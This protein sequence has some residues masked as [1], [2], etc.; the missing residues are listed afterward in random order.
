M[1]K[2]GSIFRAARLLIA[3]A[4]SAVL[5]AGCA[6]RSL[7]RF[8][9]IAKVAAKD[10]YLEAVG[11]IRKEEGLYGSQAK[12]LYNMDLGILFHYA[13]EW[14][15]SIV[16]L[17][18][19]VKIHDA[20]FT[21][22]VTN[23][24]VSFVAN[25]NARP[26][27]GRPH[28]M[29]LVH[30]FLAFD[31]LAKGKPDEAR[32]EARQ[33]QILL[34]EI[35]RK[36]GPKDFRDDGMFRYFSALTYEAVGERDDAAISYYQSVKAY[37]EG[38]V[39]LPGAVARQA[40]LALASAGREDDIK[41]LDLSQAT[42]PTRDAPGGA[43][44]AAGEGEIIVVGHAGRAPTVDQTVFWGT[45]VRDG[46]L[47]IHWRNAK[48]EEFTEALP[49]PGLPPRELEKAEKGRRTRSGTTLHIKFAMPE[50]KTIPSRTRYFTVAGADLGAPVRTES[51]TD[52]DGL[53]REDLEDNR[54]AVLA[55]TVARVVLRTIASQ[56][57]KEAL[58]TGNPILNLL[59]NIGTDVLSDQLEQADSRCWFLLPRSIQVARIPVKPGTHSLTVAAQDGS[60]AVIKTRT[61]ES[62]TVRAGEKKYLFMPS[63][64]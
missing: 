14:D 24:A 25:D 8:E 38:A 52:L 3:G 29:I 19:A 35:R 30:Q 18:E 63:L 26:Y 55:R 56:Q 58:N 11:R 4:A 10:D 20:L 50:L 61:F 2:S 59:L 31:Y 33:G 45:W 27:R 36:A 64:Q 57:T 41:T 34:D 46:V 16:Y 7:V 51:L 6:N 37:R 12:L 54:G 22:S 32:V 39:P 9:K 15:S 53:L 49:A 1:R 28:E 23:E 43:P 44:P 48:G 21:K 60:G 42:A 5:L 13:G 62:V 17:S 47:V 40:R